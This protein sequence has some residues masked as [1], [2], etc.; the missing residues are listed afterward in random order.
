MWSQLK[1]HHN[2][3]EYPFVFYL[4]LVVSDK[5]KD[6]LIKVISSWLMDCGASTKILKQVEYEDVCKDTKNLSRSGCFQRLWQWSKKPV[7]IP[8]VGHSPIHGL[9]IF[10]NAVEK[11]LRDIQEGLCQASFP[12]LLLDLDVLMARLNF[13]ADVLVSYR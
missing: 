5:I 10:Q 13:L 11:D 3:Y 6:F 8:N 7:F 1:T 12:S 2:R 9:Q 4:I